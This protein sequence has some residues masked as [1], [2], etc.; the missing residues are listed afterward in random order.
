MIQVDH[1]HPGVGDDIDDPRRSLP[2][3]EIDLFEPFDELDGND[4]LK[5]SN[6]LGCPSVAPEGETAERVA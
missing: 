2:S 6:H 4:L 5:P 3:A 1:S